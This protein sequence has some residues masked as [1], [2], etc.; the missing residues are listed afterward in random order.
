M[1]P[2]GSA[3]PYSDVYKSTTRLPEIRFL[4]RFPREQRSAPRGVV[5]PPKAGERRRHSQ[6]GGQAAMGLSRWA[7]GGGAPEAGERW[8]HTPRPERR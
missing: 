4:W 2:S 3:A 6:A 5:A 1:M 8:Q 7:S